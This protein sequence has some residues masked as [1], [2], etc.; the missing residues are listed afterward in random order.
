MDAAGIVA[1]EARLRAEMDA[2]IHAVEERVAVAALSGGEA[3]MVARMAQLEGQVGKWLDCG[4]C[5]AIVHTC[6]GLRCRCVAGQRPEGTVLIMA[7][8]S[9]VSINR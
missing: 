5:H 1:I 6:L 3:G 2:R 7:A 8:R 4:T 9:V